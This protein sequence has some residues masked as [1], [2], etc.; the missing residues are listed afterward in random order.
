MNEGNREVVVKED[1][2]SDFFLGLLMLMG[3]IVGVITCNFLQNYSTK[4]WPVPYLD[5][6]DCQSSLSGTEHRGYVCEIRKDGYLWWPKE[7]K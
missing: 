3:F 6:F 5:G 1:K 7:K 2:P 4:D